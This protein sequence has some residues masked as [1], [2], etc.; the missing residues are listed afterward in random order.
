[1]NEELLTQETLMDWSA[2][3]TKSALIRW[4]TANHIPFTFSSKKKIVTTV[5]AVNTGLLGIGQHR[6]VQVV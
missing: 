2:A 5:S 6:E 1:M 4:L 3:K